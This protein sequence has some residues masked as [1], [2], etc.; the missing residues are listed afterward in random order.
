M[1]ASDLLISDT[2][3]PVSAIDASRL[4]NQ[5]YETFLITL[6]QTLQSC[7]LLKINLLDIIERTESIEVKIGDEFCWVWSNVIRFP[8]FCRLSGEIAGVLLGRKSRK[9]ILNCWHCWVFEKKRLWDKKNQAEGK[10]SY[11][12]CLV[13]IKCRTLCR[14]LS[15]KSE[16]TCWQK[17]P[18]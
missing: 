10:W 12:C 17:Y 15:S 7:L 8:I 14:G 16:R 13:D 1:L 2:L 3:T 18:I 6:L 5:T 9:D 4:R 11:V